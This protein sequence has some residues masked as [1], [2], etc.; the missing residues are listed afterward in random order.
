MALTRRT[1]VKGLAASGAVALSGG[2]LGH[3][4]SRA[5]SLVSH[6]RPLAIPPL[7]KGERRGDARSYELMIRAG[8]RGFLPGRK[9]PTIGV[10]GDYLG[11]TLA[12]ARARS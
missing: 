1:V 11:P 2:L 8:A 3:S 5:R 10:N 6:D 4:L 12:C 9:T 7:L